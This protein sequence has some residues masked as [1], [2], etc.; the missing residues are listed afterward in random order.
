MDMNHFFAF[1]IGMLLFDLLFKLLS[2]IFRLIYAII[3]AIFNFFARRGRTDGRQDPRVSYAGDTFKVQLKAGPWNITE[4]IA[5]GVE[6]YYLRQTLVGARIENLSRQ[7]ADVLGKLP[8]EIR[9]LLRR[10]YS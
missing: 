10:Y 8:K 5:P 4:T 3:N 1:L 9:L 7:P 6:L 2:L